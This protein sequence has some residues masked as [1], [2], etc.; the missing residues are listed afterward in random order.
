MKTNKE[1]LDDFGKKVIEECYDGLLRHFESLRKKDI[2]PEIFKHKKDFLNIL[3]DKS[4]QMFRETLG[5]SAELIF[6]EFFNILEE[7]PEFK[8]IYEEDGRQV[9]LTKISEM[10]KAEPII[11]G[12]WI[13]RFSKEL[14]K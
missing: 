8:I 10:L 2:L 13:D 11:E 7:N 5:G 9:D 3:D 4:Y 6:F 12:G 14:K 1:I